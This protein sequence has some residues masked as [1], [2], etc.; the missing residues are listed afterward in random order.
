MSES[1]SLGLDPNQFDPGVVFRIRFKLIDRTNS[2]YFM[3]RRRTVS[4]SVASTRFDGVDNPTL[5]DKISQIEKHFIKLYL[6]RRKQRRNKTHPILDRDEDIV[7][8]GDSKSDDS[9][10]INLLP[11][12]SSTMSRE[13]SKRL[14]PKSSKQGGFRGLRQ[15]FLKNDSDLFSQEIVVSVLMMIDH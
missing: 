10:T 4:N 8:D 1:E 6:K 12:Q 2:H 14:D 5:D 9:F 7:D 13:P 3:A 15:S 11:L